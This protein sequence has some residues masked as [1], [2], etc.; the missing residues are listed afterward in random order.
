MPEFTLYT[1]NEDDLFGVNDYIEELA[2]RFHIPLMY[3]TSEGLST[4]PNG[5][6]DFYIAIVRDGFKGPLLF[7]AR[8]QPQN[9]HPF[10]IQKTNRITFNGD[11]ITPE[12]IAE[13]QREL[14]GQ[15]PIK[16]KLELST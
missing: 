7:T 2:G 15:N 1:V 6:E 14:S 10:D 4:K 16:L 11:L 13:I 12:I 3:M 8:Y 9:S 5:R